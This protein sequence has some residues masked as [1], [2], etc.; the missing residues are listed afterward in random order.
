M[1][2]YVD[3]GVMAFEAVIYRPDVVGASSFVDI[4]FDVPA[5]YGAKG[6][7]P[8]LAEFD[9]HAYRGSLVTFGG[10]GHRILVLGDV[11]AAIGKGPGDSV[12][13]SLRLDTAERVVEIE[14]D[15]EDALR[16][17]NQLDT[18]RALSYSHQKEYWVWISGA[19]KP[20]TREARTAKM[21]DML[22]TGQRL[23]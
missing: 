15:V 8:V 6:R 23:K 13:V 4:P 1:V 9:R 19:K 11:Q 21:L 22:A 16:A 20:E 17:A 12:H 14:A 2:A 10:P 5:T 7:V 3:P 18:F